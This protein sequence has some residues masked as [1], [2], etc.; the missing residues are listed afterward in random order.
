MSKVFL[1]RG[2]FYNQTEGNFTMSPTLDDG[3][4]RIHYDPMTGEITLEKISDK[5][6]F[7]FKLYGVDETL[8]NHVLNTYNKQETKRNI[9]IL[10]NGTKGTGK[11]VTA[12]VLCNRLGLPVIICDAPIPPLAKFLSSINHDCIFL[13]D[14]FEKNFALRDSDD[15]EAAGESLLSI[16]DGVYN[17]DHCHVFI[18]TT[19]ELR[20]NDNLLSRPSRI[21][22]VKSFG[23]VIDRKILELY[24]DDNLKYPEYKDE[25][26]DF[27]D[28][29]T[30]ATIDIVKAIVDE[31]NIHNCHIDEFKNIFNVKEA[32]YYYWIRNW[33]VEENDREPVTKEAFLSKVKAPYDENSTWR[34]THDSLRTKKPITKFK[35]GEFLHGAW[36]IESIDLEKQYIYCVSMARHNMFCHYYIENINAKPSLY[37]N[38]DGG[39]RSEM[40]LWN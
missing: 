22:Y 15:N 19:N 9:G 24:I 33:R 14:E 16:M 28:T 39:Y 7:G 17:A 13:F 12:K 25:I 37:D 21:R 40:G 29:L 2:P 11:T 34:P 31:I 1:K 4:Y 5:F 38:N 32:E 30:L 8:I 3:I 10:L 36:K 20:I 18:L 35:V 23:D 6:S 26:L 27:I